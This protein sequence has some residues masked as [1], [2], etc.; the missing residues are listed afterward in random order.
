MNKMNYFKT[1]FSFFNSTDKRFLSVLISMMVFTAGIEL[2]GIGSIFPYIKILGDQKIIHSNYLL[3]AMYNF[4]GFTSDNHFLILIGFFIFLMILFKGCMSCL[5]N[6]FQ[7]KFTYQLN[8][9]LADFCLESFLRM[10]YTEVINANSAMLSKHLLADVASVSATL[11]A[12]LTMLTDIIVALA[13]ISL[14]IWADPFLVSTVVITLC[15]FLWLTVKVTKNRI[16][17]LSK[18]N[19]KSNR[20]AYKTASEALSA[21]KDIKIYQVENY[22]IKKFLEWQ[23]KLSSQ[24]LQFNFISNLPS[25][26]MN[27]VGF[28]V[29]LIALLYLMITEGN[30]VTILPTIGLIAICVQRL[31]PSATRIST[32]IGL[33]RRYKPLVFIV[34][35]AMTSLLGITGKR[36]EKQQTQPKVNFNEVLSLKDVYF[37]YPHTERYALSGITLDI[38]KNTSLGIVGESGAGKSTFIDVLLGLLSIEKGQI[39]CDHVDITKHENLALATLVGYVPQQTFLID[40][41]LKENIAFGVEKN[42]FNLSALQKAIKIA[43]LETFISALP[44]GIETHIGENG[45]KISGGQRQRVGIARALYHDPEILILDEATNALDASTENEFNESLLRLMK[46]KTI[47]IIAHRLSSIKN[48]QSVIQLEAG[49]IVAQ[50]SY[51]ELFKTSEKFRQI[52]DITQEIG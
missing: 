34:R 35:N 49:K 45:V 26:A 29:L 40:G 24:L 8:N 52:Y 31:L 28:C 27:V 14:M 2:L 19:E 30:L 33:I 41:T 51:K 7:S 42:N 12:I 18:I 17:H 47:I 23:Y 3:D 39:W 21:I 1:I 43:Q 11:S 10:P 9:R 37:K 32:S 6:Y 13:L 25:V 4:F 48:C 44:E 50:G 36:H 16:K 20:Y 46:E 5:N 38:K 22:F 15:G